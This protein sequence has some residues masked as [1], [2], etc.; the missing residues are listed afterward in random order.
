MFQNQTISL[1]LFYFFVSLFFSLVRSSPNDGTSSAYCPKSTCNGIEISYPFWRLDNYNSSAPQY[2]GYPGFGI[3]CSKNQPHPIIY[4]PGDAFYVKDIDYETYSLNLVDIDVFNLQCPRARHNLTLEKLPLI[5]SPSDLNL[6]FYFNCTG[7]LPD[8]LPAE[9]LNSGANRTYFYVG[10][11]EPES[12]WFEICDEKV[13]STVTEKRSFQNDDWIEGF[14][15]AM[16]E[17]FMLDWRSAAECG[18]CEASDGRCGY[19]NSTQAYLCYCEDGTVKFEHCKGTPKISF[20]L[21][22]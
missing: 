10:G 15:R 12:N 16:G 18:L 4:F 11:P 5:F 3:N 7:P 17:G 2:C 13:V 8:A 1:L 9:C 6:T 22:F 19:N 20:F 14:G 21:F